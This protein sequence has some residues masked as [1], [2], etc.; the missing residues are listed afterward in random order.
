[1]SS[2]DPGASADRAGASALVSAS[3]SGWRW[4]PLSVIVILLDQLTKAWV[5][6]VLEVRRNGADDVSR[7]GP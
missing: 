6:R 1:M 3:M 5:V 4:L 7:R 2:S